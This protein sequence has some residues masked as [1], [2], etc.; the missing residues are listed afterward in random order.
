MLLASAK[1]GE[2]CSKYPREHGEGFRLLT[3]IGAGDDSNDERKAVNDKTGCRFV[4]L[5]GVGGKSRS[6]S[7]I[8]VLCAS[9]GFKN[10]VVSGI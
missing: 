3:R 10:I 7:S 1:M 2:L 4:S 9:E 6:H 5:R 8:V